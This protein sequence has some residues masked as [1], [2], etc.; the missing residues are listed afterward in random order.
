MSHANEVVACAIVSAAGTIC[1]CVGVRVIRGAGAVSYGVK[2]CWLALLTPKTGLGYNILKPLCCRP[3]TSA[4]VRRRC[5][6]G[7]TQDK[8]S[9]GNGP[10]TGNRDSR[11]PVRCCIPLVIC[12]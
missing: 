6:C 8:K 12:P 1:R 3:M 9:R 7:D 4:G 2:L 10:L 11:R 5:C